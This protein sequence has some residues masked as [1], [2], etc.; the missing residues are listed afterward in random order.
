MWFTIR[1]ANR[2]TNASACSDMKKMKRISSILAAAVFALLYGGTCASGAQDDYV[3][4]TPVLS[5]TVRADGGFLRS[6]K[7]EVYGREVL[8]APT[9]EFMLELE[10]NGSVRTLAPAD[11]EVKDVSKAKLGRLERTQFTLTSRLDELPITLYVR[12]FV[13]PD[14]PYIQKTVAVKPFGRIR[15]ATLRRVVVDDLSLSDSLR[16]PAPECGG[17]I[18]GAAAFDPASRTG[19]FW[20][21]ASLTGSERLGRSR[22]LTLSEECEH[23]MDSPYETGRAAIGGARGSADE[24]ARAFRDYLSR[25]FAAAPKGK[26]YKEAVCEGT[27][28]K[29][30]TELADRCRNLRKEHPNAA[31]L[32]TLERPVVSADFHLL[33]AVD[34]L[35]I[36]CSRMSLLD[37]RRTRWNAL[38]AAPPQ[39]LR[40]VPPSAP[41]EA[42]AE[43]KTA[44]D[45]ASLADNDAAEP[46]RR[47][48]RQRFGRY[49]D[50]WQPILNCPNGK[51]VDGEAHIADNAGF[52]FLFNP[53]GESQNASL[54]LGPP[55]MELKGELKLSDWTSLE[56]GRPLKSVRAGETVEFQLAAH[57]AMV[58]GINV[59]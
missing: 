34:A 26:E 45:I 11:F 49:L 36:D 13:S 39:A 15:G 12:Y 53:S 8:S 3:I 22:A 54:L 5:R 43:E 30:L 44:F 29:S 4:K 33:N 35:R 58:L 1:R 50:A 38:Q 25:T 40:F 7:L 23:P 18:N 32:L 28:A 21:Q 37:F 2:G 57:S 20:F 52:I 48:F 41:S 51:D 42:S 59:D 24:L 10:V 27:S 31:I 17:P 14:W 46:E 9:V 56:S 19:I 47:A 6:I 55:A 16:E